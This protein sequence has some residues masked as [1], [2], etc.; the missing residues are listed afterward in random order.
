[1]K[2]NFTLESMRFAAAKTYFGG[3]RLCLFILAVTLWISFA[4][5][6]VGPVESIKVAR[7]ETASGQ[8]I[9]NARITSSC[10]ESITFT[11]ETGVSRVMVDDFPVTQRS[12]PDAVWQ[13]IEEIRSRYPAFA[14]A[15]E[16]SRQLK[17]E[18][19]REQEQV[20]AES[21]PTI[22]ENLTLEIPESKGI[23]A[24]PDQSPSIDTALENIVEFPEDSASETRSDVPE[25][26]PSE[27]AAVALSLRLG[28]DTRTSAGKAVMEELNELLSGIAPTNIIEVPTGI[29]IFGGVFS[30]MP[31]MEA[32]AAVGGNKSRV[33]KAQVAVGGWPNSSTHFH[34]ID[35]RDTPPFNRLHF[36][37][38]DA[39][40]VIA[41]QLVEE[42]P[43][44][45]S[46]PNRP[47]SWTSYDFVNLR[48]SG[49]KNL[50]VFAAV[51][52]EENLVVIE[53]KLIDPRR[54]P[55][56]RYYVRLMMPREVAGIIKY[57]LENNL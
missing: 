5:A 22:N 46:S 35:Y 8:I 41:V 45:S 30:M 3:L 53:S 44:S 23:P 4:Q 52:N 57:C 11:H 9:K 37:T 20:V 12:L 19:A 6:N 1:M 14:S 56:D 38:D 25:A 13:L 43:K 16:A 54:S 42:A 31:L 17:R 21:T 49:S 48:R 27:P 32:I 18:K 33:S 55:A 7:L 40:R 2:A 24:E 15:R 28:W 26:T 39:D 50:G 36:V 10:P 29:P 51:R 34:S 47:S